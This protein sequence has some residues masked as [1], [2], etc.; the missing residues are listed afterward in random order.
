VLQESRGFL[1]FRFVRLGFFKA[2]VAELVVDIPLVGVKEHGVVGIEYFVAFTAMH[3][4]SHKT[5]LLQNVEGGI[6]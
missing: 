2:V 3:I 4:M 5:I 1:G 6:R